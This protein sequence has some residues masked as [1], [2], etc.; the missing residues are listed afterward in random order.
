MTPTDLTFIQPQWRPPKRY[1]PLMASP[2]SA[3]FPS[4]AEDYEETRIDL[5]EH[6]VKNQPATFYARLGEHA[7]S[8][9]GAGIHP[10]DIVVIDRSLDAQPGDVVLACVNGEFTLK[11]YCKDKQ[12]G[13]IWLK[14]ENPAYAAIHFSEG[15]EMEV[16]GVVKHSVRHH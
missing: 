15:D 5:N 16:W 14:A 7:D 3:G 4:P 11:R 13:K 2:V 1:I 10:G 9:I 6:M 12:T 8:M